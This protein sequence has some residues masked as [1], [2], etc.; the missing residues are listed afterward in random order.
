MDQDLEKRMILARDCLLS[1]GIVLVATETYYAL[2]TD[3]FSFSSLKRLIGLKGRPDD[4]PIP[5]IAASVAEVTPHL[6]EK[7]DTIFKLI[8]EFWPGS[9]TIALKINR[10]FPPGLVTRQDR[11]A[12]RTPPPCPAQKLAG[13]ARGWITSTSANI[14]GLP[15]AL[16]VSDVSESLLDQVDL[17]LDTGPAPGGDVST[18]VTPFEKGVR[19]ERKGAVSVSSLESALGFPLLKS[20]D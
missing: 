11:V 13:L 6:C 2:A 17:V 18:I 8:K 16:K 14:S 10:P 19:L 3:P 9:L 5:L 7:S 15:P 20:G 1:G 12:V 4:K